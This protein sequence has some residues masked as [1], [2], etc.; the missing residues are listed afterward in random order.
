MKRPRGV[1]AIAAYHVIFSVVLLG[2]LVWQSASHHPS[3]GWVFAAPVLG[4]LFFLC[5][6]PAVLAYGLWIMDD[7]ARIGTIIFTILHAISTVVYIQHTPGLWLPWGR[8]AVDG[9]ILAYLFFRSTRQSFEEE[10][11]LLLRWTD[12]M[13]SGASS[14]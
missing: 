6:A 9:A 2:I 13:H 10:H 5:L 12:S 8:L 7:G 1:V 3:D 11:K 14:R 4:M